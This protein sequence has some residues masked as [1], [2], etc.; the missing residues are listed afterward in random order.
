MH[1]RTSCAWAVFV[2]F[3]FH[4]LAILFCRLVS[5]LASLA[6]LLSDHVNST[7]GCRSQP[8]LEQLQIDTPTPPR[9]FSLHPSGSFP[10]NLSSWFIN[11]ISDASLFPSKKI[12][13][14]I[15]Y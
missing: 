3:F 15:R 7:W 13:F 9:A 10:R 11:R 4:P 12:S 2:R 6:C 14:D 5:A 1:K 8:E